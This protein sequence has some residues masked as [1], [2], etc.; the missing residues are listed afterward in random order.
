MLQRK[1]PKPQSIIN[2]EQQKIKQTTLHLTFPVSVLPICVTIKAGLY[3]IIS[4]MASRRRRRV[5]IVVWPA[6]FGHLRTTASEKKHC[7][8]KRKK[9]SKFEDKFSLAFLATFV[10]AEF[11]ET[12]AQNNNDNRTHNRNPRNTTKQVFRGL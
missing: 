10:A 2:K 1:P 5:S 9:S 4:S 3:T 7:K 6:F 12:A 11:R 8:R